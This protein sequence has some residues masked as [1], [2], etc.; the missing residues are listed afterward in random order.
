M[1]ENQPIEEVKKTLEEASQ[2]RATTMTPGWTEI[3]LPFMENTKQVYADKLLTTEWETL[4]EQRNCWAKYKAIDEIL[5]LIDM[6]LNEAA[7]I[8]K[9][10][11]IDE[12][13]KE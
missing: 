4:D 12:V 13:T 3:L 8:E 11:A 6:K 7:E 5:G 2:I 1:N 10:L 9:Q